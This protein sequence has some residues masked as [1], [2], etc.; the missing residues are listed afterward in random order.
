MRNKNVFIK[1]STM[2]L[3]C[4]LLLCGCTPTTITDNSSS[5]SSNIEPPVQPEPI[6]IL[7]SY[8]GEE[9][10]TIIDIGDGQ[11]L[12]LEYSYPG[13][14]GEFTDTTIKRIDIVNDTVCCKRVLEGQLEPVGNCSSE[15]IWM[16][17]T[18]GD[19][20]D[21]SSLYKLDNELNI[22]KKI[23]VSSFNGIFSDDF[24]KYYFVKATLLYALDTET[25][26]ITYIELPYSL[27]FSTVNGF[28]LET[29]CLYGS[30]KACNEELAAIMDVNDKTFHLFTKE[31]QNIKNYGSTYYCAAFDEGEEQVVY[32]Q[33][34]PDDENLMCFIHDEQDEYY[35]DFVDS[36]NYL[37]GTKTKRQSDTVEYSEAHTRVCRFTD[38]N[39]EYCD[40]DSLEFEEGLSN[41]TYIPDRQ[42]LIGSST[43]DDRHELVLINLNLLDYEKK[44][45]IQNRKLQKI[46]DSKLW[47]ENE[48]M[49]VIPEVSPE[50]KDA[51]AFADDI[52]K[53]YSV[54]VLISN[55]CS[56]ASRSDS[57]IGYEFKT[58]DQESSFEP[59]KDRIMDCL[60]QL[61]S[62]LSQ[63]PDNFFKRFH[64][65]DGVG[66][67]RYLLVGSITGDDISAAG[68]ASTNDEWYNAVIDISYNDVRSTYHHETWHNIEDLCIACGVKCFELNEWS[69]LNPKDFEYSIDY[70]TSAKEREYDIYFDAPTSEYYFIDD[71]SMV[72]GWEDRARLFEYVMSPKADSNA[73]FSSSKTTAKFK[74]MVDTVR[75][76]WD[77]SDWKSVQWEDELKSHEQ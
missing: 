8:S 48:K 66:G 29:N 41:A 10:P 31:L 65:Y 46:V 27:R 21:D 12:T 33:G 28:D 14:M 54:T 69:K 20:L 36:S 63:Y 6:Q 26:E 75:E 16:M 35:Y 5:S 19:F 44:M 74:V 53:K 32:Y 59:E 7:S 39:I 72:D 62:V 61:D 25:E 73:V 45:P 23:S 76:V 17:N 1:I 70:Y 38:N 55:Q 34:T 30:V 57:F 2:L 37:V 67:L 64:T 13:E 47:E 24:K 3:I 58:T 77:T 18:D 15:N 11:V 9:A 51:R 43:I 50:L 40:L 52:E 49:W 60:Q 71:Y 22:E 56:I 4:C 42:C 68:Y